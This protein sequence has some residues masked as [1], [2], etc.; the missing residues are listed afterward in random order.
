MGGNGF[1]QKP[2]EV[3]IIPFPAP[4]PDYSSIEQKE[5]IQKASEVTTIPSTAQSHDSSSIG[6]N[7]S[8]KKL[9]EVVNTTRPPQD[10]NHR[11]V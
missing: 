10:P 11:N 3:I 7:E 9:F 2:P 6:G 1:T 8:T 4:P 5:L